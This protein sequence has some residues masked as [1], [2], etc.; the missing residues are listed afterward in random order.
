MVV[1]KTLYDK[2]EVD[3]NISQDELKKK[4]KKLLIKWHP[5]KHP[6]NVEFATKKFQ[7][8]QEALHILEN[9]EKRKIYD[10]HGMDGV[11]GDVPGG[12]NPFG[13]GFPFGPGFPF[14]DMFGGGGGFPGAQFNMFPQRE[15][16]KENVMEKLKVTLKQI[17]K[18]EMVELKYKHKICCAKCNGEGSNDG[19][20][21]DCNDCGGKGLRTQVMRMGPMIQQSIVPCNACR[22]KGKK[23]PDQNKC[24][25]CTGTGTLEKEKTIPIPLKN[26]LTNGVNL[27]LEGKGHHLKNTKTDLIVVIE[28]DEDSV[29]KRTGSDL[30]IE[31]DLK[32]FQALFGFNK[33]IE[34]LDGRKLL[35]QHTG[36]TEFGTVRKIFGEGMKDLRTGM[37]GDLIIKFNID[38]PTITNETLIKALTLTD[39]S[40]SKKEK[41]ILTEENLIKTIMT[42]VTTYKSN[43]NNT[44]SDDDSGDENN[45]K[46]GP[47]ECR[48]Q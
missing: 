13:Q 35:L 45:F 7:E 46:E 32:L 42:D 21:T 19:S 44:V 2:L 41:T 4:A 27:Q 48:Q 24:E 23:I 34:H 20:K 8:L 16:R 33:V 12:G 43:K 30:V 29:F 10:E 39:K 37:K 28:V 14:G 18:E 9:P 15:E 47:S 17:F 11:K 31:I 25:S 6:D 22:G 36:K 38:L 5:D 1:D 40:E 3:P 26:G